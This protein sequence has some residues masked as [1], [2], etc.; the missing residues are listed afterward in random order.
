MSDG[1][2]MKYFVL[3]PKGNDPYHAASRAAM[4]AY[5]EAIR[6]TNLE[7]CDDLLKWV[8]RET[9]SQQ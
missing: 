8:I 9:P 2:Q 5:A 3:K 7:L 4:V 1:L 6:S